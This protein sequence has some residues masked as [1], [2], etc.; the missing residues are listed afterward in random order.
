VCAIIKGE[1]TY[2]PEWIDYHS[3]LGV[4]QFY[5]YDNGPGPEVTRL[6]SYRL[7]VTVYSTAACGSCYT[8]LYANTRFKV[9]HESICP[10]L[11]ED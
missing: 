4:G 11:F 6:I 7:L 3:H 9:A 1:A 10:S 2:L 5:L 8:Q